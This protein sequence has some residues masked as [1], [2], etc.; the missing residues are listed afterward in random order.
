MNTRDAG[1]ATDRMWGM[2]GEVSHGAGHSGK[3]CNREV[4]FIIIQV[5]NLTPFH[6]EHKIFWGQVLIHI[7][8]S[9]NATALYRKIALFC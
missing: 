4:L 8:I 3:L 1:Q 2:Q 6:C 5:Y 9:R 7:N